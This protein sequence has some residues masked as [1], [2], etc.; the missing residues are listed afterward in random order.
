MCATSQAQQRQRNLPA[1]GVAGLLAPHRVIL[2]GEQPSTSHTYAHGSG[3]DKQ[4]TSLNRPTLMLSATPLSHTSSYMC[5]IPASTCNCSCSPCS[6]WCERRYPAVA[7]YVRVVRCER[8][9]VRCAPVSDPKTRILEH[10]HPCLYACHTLFV[11]CMAT[12]SAV[13]LDTH[14]HT[15]AHTHSHMHARWQTL[16]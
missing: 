12:P 11:E 16:I 5:T 2:A 1:Q 9:A 4:T 7:T 13:R 8:N 6:L 15:H 10:T 14:T 3:L